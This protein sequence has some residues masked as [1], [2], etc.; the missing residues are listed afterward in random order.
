MMLRMRSH[1]C[2]FLCE[3]LTVWQ[4]CTCFRSFACEVWKVP[5][6]CFR[7]RACFTFFSSF[8]K[9]RR[10]DVTV[11]RSCNLEPFDNAGSA[12]DTCFCSKL[13][14]ED[15]TIITTVFKGDHVTAAVFETLCFSKSSCDKR[16]V[17]EIERN[18]SCIIR[19]HSDYSADLFRSSPS[20]ALHL[21]MTTF[22]IRLWMRCLRL[23]CTPL[24]R[25]RCSE[26]SKHV[27]HVRCLRLNVH[28]FLQWQQDLP[29]MIVER[30]QSGT[31]YTLTHAIDLP[32]E[33][34]SKTPSFFCFSSFGCTGV[35]QS[36]YMNKKHE[37]ALRL[38]ALR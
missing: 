17:K 38:F 15:A 32:C 35:R 19:V 14:R 13:P 30:G 22:K 9:P 29:L 18:A 3:A 34:S 20:Y 7:E 28:R 1:S 25:S 6:E 4:V 16:Q 8:S 21:K 12:M 24:R 11:R 36:V 10:D 27:P 33:E 2:D 23:Q 31:V 5:R 26:A 37:Q